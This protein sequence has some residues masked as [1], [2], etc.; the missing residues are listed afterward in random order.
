MAK[1]H[2]VGLGE[3]NEMIQHFHSESDRGAAILVGSFAEHALGTYLTHHVKDKGVG[4][5]LF[6]PVGPLSSFS[7]RIAVAYAFGLINQRQY[8][9]FEAIRQV[10]NYFAHH[11]LEA[12][13]DSPEVQKHTHTLP[14]FS[15]P[16]LSTCT[17]PRIKHRMTYLLTCGLLCGRLLDIVKSELE[18][19]NVPKR[20]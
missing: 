12:T 6:G 4:E 20:S 5:K 13:F 8:K 15:D 18:Q 16:G 14:Y 19:V 1:P 7:Q 3:W 9:E 10:R 17:D 11:P 2:I